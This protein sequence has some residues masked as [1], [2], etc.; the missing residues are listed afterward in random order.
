[1]LELALTFSTPKIYHGFYKHVVGTQSEAVTWSATVVVGEVRKLP[2]RRKPY[3]PDMSITAANWVNQMLY[4][5]S[6]KVVLVLTETL[7]VARLAM[8][9]SMR[10]SLGL[11]ASLDVNG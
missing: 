1:M 6:A 8:Q 4:S 5:F 2:A 3:P 9:D 11:S 10:S 7:A